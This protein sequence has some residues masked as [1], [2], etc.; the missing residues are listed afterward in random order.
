[1]E[2]FAMDRTLEDL[3]DCYRTHPKSNFPRLQHQ[4]RTKRDRELTKILQK[5]GKNRLQDI[6]LPTLLY[7]YRV[8]LGDN[9]TARVQSF[10]R[11]FRELFRFGYLVLGDQD[12]GHLVEALSSL[13]LK[14]ARPQ[15]ARMTTDHVRA[16][17]RTARDHF[18]W[19]SIALVQALQFELSL[20]QKDVIGEWVPVG[21]PGE[22]DIVI[23]ERK[24][25]RGARW[26]AIDENFILRHRAGSSKRLVEADLRAAPIVFDQL[27]LIAGHD[28][29]S[30]TD[31]L[32]RAQSLPASGPIVICEI[33]GLPWTT[34]EF[35]R[36]WRLVAKKAGVPD[37]ITNRHSSARN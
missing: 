11:R 34:A 17:C 18:G 35:R 12:C 29:S 9:K 3:I 6:R 32:S 22:S 33:N 15:Q 26:S 7:W 20:G 27:K 36:K 28:T 14:H 23:G 16:I 4:V 2:G 24:W 37:H 5:H 8:W 1:M 13:Q 10:V 25:L 19:D 21:E 30:P 31:F